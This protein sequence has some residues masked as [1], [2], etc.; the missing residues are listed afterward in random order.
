MYD[1][2]I[3]C[4][5]IHLIESFELR[6][7]PIEMVLFSLQFEQLACRFVFQINVSF[8]LECF[9]IDEYGEIQ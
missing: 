7:L 5:V 4:S 8:I 6:Y 1:R 3:Y 9:W 2:E